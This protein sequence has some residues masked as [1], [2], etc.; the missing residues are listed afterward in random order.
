MVMA[1]GVVMDDGC[2]G[3]RGREREGVGEEVTTMVVAVV[4]MDGEYSFWGGER[5]RER[6]RE[7]GGGGGGEQRPL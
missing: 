7:W 4:V 6:K 3:E 2:L 1:A 5:E